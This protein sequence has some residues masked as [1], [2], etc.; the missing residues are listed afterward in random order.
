M[1]MPDITAALRHVAVFGEGKEL[2]L[3]GV[4]DCRVDGV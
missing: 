2:E 3:D 4:E 1:A